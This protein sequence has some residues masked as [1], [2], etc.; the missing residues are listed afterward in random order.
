MRWNITSVNI[1]SAKACCTPLLKPCCPEVQPQ[2][3]YPLTDSINCRSAP[4]QARATL[5]VPPWNHQQPSHCA[6]PSFADLPLGEGPPGRPRHAAAHGKCHGPCTSRPGARLTHTG[7]TPV[8]PHLSHLRLPLILEAP[9][10]APPP[11]ACASCLPTSTRIL[12]TTPQHTTSH[13]PRP[14][15]R[16]GPP[17][18]HHPG[19]GPAA[20]PA[21]PGD[22]AEPHV[23]PQAGHHAHGRVHE[24]RGAGRSQTA[25]VAH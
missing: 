13:C 24:V 5:S 20:L 2:A 4:V 18:A 10:C 1:P 8:T 7:C 14:R 11:R 23:P 9:R 15:P 19:A 12:R 22:G 17:A 6:L 3:S 21:G 25:Q 16:P